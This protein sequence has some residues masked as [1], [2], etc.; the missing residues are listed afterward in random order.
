MLFNFV[1]DALNKML[2]KAA[3][4]GLVAS[5]LQQFRLEGIVALQYADDTLL[6][7]SDNNSAL[8]NLKGYL[9]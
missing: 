3:R 9:V 1:G 4:R 5:L 2:L 6:F 8:E 7:S